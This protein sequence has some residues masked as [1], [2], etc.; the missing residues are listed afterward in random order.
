[1]ADAVVV[2]NRTPG[3]AW[4]WHPVARVADLGDGPG[5]RRVELLGQGYVL[6][7]LGGQWRGFADRCP[8]RLG[9][10]SGGTVAEDRLVC[11]YHGWQFADGGQCRLIPALGPE[12]AVPRR[13]GLDQVEV[14][15]RYGLLWLAPNRPLAG[16]AEV[17][18]WDD[19]ALRQV[20]L[21]VVDVRAG[22]AQFVD[23][24]LDFAHF[25]FVHAGTF[26]N[27]EEPFVEEFSVERAAHGAVV[28]YR[29]T[30]VNHEDPLVADGTHPLVQPRRMRY[31]YTAPFTALLRLDLEL[32][33][34][35]NAILVACQPVD[36]GVTRLYT[37]MLRND[38]ADD[39]AARAAVDYELSVLAED[40]AVIDHL[41]DTTVTLDPTAQVH[42]RADR[43]T[44]EFRR[45]LR[46]LLIEAAAQAG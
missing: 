36:V 43:L 7:R 28:D 29:H 13:A 40:L 15:E 1:M 42:T 25:P 33:G 14:C 11:P 8:H 41:P 9:R 38:C 35:V 46:D 16:L 17:A 37:V 18:E 20:W 3:L 26:G 19:P 6:A 10:L 45:V 27:A 5:P 34:M 44:V 30:I 23:N 24:F 32:T 4:C 39:A 12:A 31:E 21:P 2:D 22:A